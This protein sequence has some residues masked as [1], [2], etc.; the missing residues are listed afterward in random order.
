MHTKRA[1]RHKD[2]IEAARTRQT[3]ASAAAQVRTAQE[4]PSSSLASTRRAGEAQQLFPSG[5]LLLLTFDFYAIQATNY[6]YVIEAL[7]QSFP[8]SIKRTLLTVLVV[9]T[10]QKT[11]RGIYFAIHALQKSC[12]RCSSNEQQTAPSLVKHVVSNRHL[13]LQISCTSLLASEWYRR[14]LSLFFSCCE[15]EEKGHQAPRP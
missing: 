9:L 11:E 4:A 8:L 14:D 10:C 13:L 5:C 12:G 6:R 2:T 1:Q 15:R 3:N 7:R